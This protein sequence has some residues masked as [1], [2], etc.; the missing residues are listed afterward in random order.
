MTAVLVIVF[1]GTAFLMTVPTIQE[2]AFL[3]LINTLVNFTSIIWLIVKF[4]KRNRKN[5]E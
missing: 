2:N 4:F 5:P 3:S 1:F